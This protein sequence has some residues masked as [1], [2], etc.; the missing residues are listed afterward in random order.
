MRFIT[1]IRQSYIVADWKIGTQL[2]CDV[3]DIMQNSFAKRM[4]ILI[5]GLTDLNTMHLNYC[6][7]NDVKVQN[8]ILDIGKGEAGAD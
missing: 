8:F 7:H 3:N 6:L 4:Q 5:S 1:S 2:D